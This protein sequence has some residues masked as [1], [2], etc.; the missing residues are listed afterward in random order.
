VARALT[1]SQN[2]QNQGAGR[3]EQSYN[4]PVTALYGEQLQVGRPRNLEDIGMSQF[5]NIGGLTAQVSTVTI[6]TAAI[7]A[8]NLNF[9]IGLTGVSVSV[10]VTPVVGDTAAIIQG[11][12]LTALKASKAGSLL[13]F[14]SV[15]ATITATA[16]DKGLNGGFDLSV[17][18]GGAGFVAAETTAPADPKPIR[19]G[20]LLVAMPADQQAPALGNPIRAALTARYAKTAAELDNLVGI[21]IRSE[22]NGENF[23]GGFNQV[24][25]LQ[26]GATGSFCKRGEI[27]VQAGPAAVLA[28]GAMFVYLDVPGVSDERVGTLTGV[29]DGVLTA[30]ISATAQI[31]LRNVFGL[32]A[33]TPAYVEIV[34][35]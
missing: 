8:Y 32:P 5:S 25:A 18:G 4:N 34:G 9:V 7:V 23:F 19:Y 12:I 26:P 21:S 11:K 28:G 20:R 6:G 14:A 17:S 3:L 35:G 30:A 2:Y 24:P 29:A 1:Q 15:A 27:V 16:R 10:S 13:N 22:V 33:N 31:K